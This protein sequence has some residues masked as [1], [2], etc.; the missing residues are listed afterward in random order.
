MNSARE[1]MLMALASADRKSADFH[2][3]RAD[4]LLRRAVGELRE[5]PEHVYD[6][7]LLRSPARQDSRETVDAEDRR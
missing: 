1:E 4:I 3:A 5:H 2:R 6:W 7:S